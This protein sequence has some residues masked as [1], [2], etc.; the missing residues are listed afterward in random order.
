VTL[1]LLGVTLICG[2]TPYND[3]ALNNTFMVG[4]NLPLG[5]VML[6]FIMIIGI[7]GPLSRWA[8]A[9]ALSSGEIAVAFAM[10]LVSCALPSSGL[11]RYFPATLIIPFWQ[12]NTRPDFV[13][14]LYEMHLPRWLFPSFSGDTPW[15][16]MRDPLTSGFA[17]RFDPEQPVPYRAWLVPALTWGVF[18][19][20]L[21]AALLC[22]SAIVRRQWFDNERLPFPLAQIQL[23]LVEAPPPRRF[24]NAIL[25]C[26][27]FWFAFAA[28][29]LVHLWNG[30]AKTDPKHFVAIP[31]Y[32]DLDAMF[33]GPPWI[34]ADYKL[35]NA[36]VFFTV[37]GVT[38]F[39]SGPVAFSLFAFFLILNIARM[40]QGTYTGDPSL[41]GVN[42]E[43]FGG[44]IAFALAILWIGRKHWVMV[45][46]QAFRGHREGEPIGRYLTYPQ[47]FWTLVICIVVM[48]AWLWLA[49]CTIG[50]AITL[51]VLLLTG[52][53]VIARIIAETGLIHGA[54]RISLVRPWQMMVTAGFANPV[55]LETFYLGS[56]LQSTHYDFREVATVYTTH[57]MRVMDQTAF[58][59][60]DA[61]VDHTH[62]RR[63]GRMFMYLLMLSLFVGY[64]V[65]F[66]ST[67]WTEYRYAWTQDVTHKVPINDWGADQNVK[68]QTIDATVKYA[69]REYF[70]QHDPIKH[71]F[72]GAGITALL[73]FLRLRYTWWPLHPI[74]FLI[75]GTYPGNHLWPS[76][77]IGWLAKTL[78]VKFGGSKFYVACK[79]FFIGLIVGEGVAAGFWLVVGIVLSA[80]GK[81]FSAVNIMP[82]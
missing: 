15:D 67:L 12:A 35:K 81:E 10:T 52:F 76:I 34:Y 5:V 11:M 1:G 30:L 39:L 59:G 73:S 66:A 63:I 18:L 40:L 50:G 51:V 58:I 41:P 71:F 68:I 77:F 31:V 64:F 55:P 62:E 49:G 20:A 74:G 8:P 61:A 32:Y 9:R 22:L 6:L 4:N 45:I 16:W 3:Y 26:R 57:G 2:L 46:A 53:L 72:I 38:Y 82:G 44:A 28:I 48:V 43:T 60:H 37:V 47:A 78:I 79:P 23:A 14:V 54:L 27:S 7:N 33:N 25:S 19:M 80:M 17:T 36:A 13:N 70:P 21:Y 42:D 56:L 69:Q 65:S 24:F 29:F 75:L